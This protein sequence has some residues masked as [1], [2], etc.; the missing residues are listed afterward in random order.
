MEG[1]N[2]A[3]LIADE[4]GEMVVLL[5]WNMKMQNEEKYH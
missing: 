5:I 4:K 1:L 2:R 3:I